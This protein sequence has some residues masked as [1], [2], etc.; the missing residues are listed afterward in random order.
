MRYFQVRNGIFDDG[1]GI[2]IGRRDN[3]GDIT[4]DENITR[5]EAENG[6]FGD[7][8]VGAAE[9]DWGVIRTVV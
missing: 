9:P 2:D 5:L 1:R 8:G 3:V 6:G 7:T 4:M